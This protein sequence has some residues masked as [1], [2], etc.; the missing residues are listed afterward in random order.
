M[1]R[2][3]GFLVLTMMVV[4]LVARGGGQDHTFELPAVESFPD[5]PQPQPSLKPNP[6]R[7]PAKRAKSDIQRA[8]SN[9]RGSG[10][11]SYAS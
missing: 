1:K 10:R 11:E 6:W 2:L 4:F 8:K 7:C 5:A 9:F 3:G